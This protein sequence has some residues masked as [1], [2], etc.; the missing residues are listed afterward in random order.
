VIRVRFLAC[1]AALFAT[2]AQTARADDEA[3]NRAY[4]VASKYGNCYAKSIPATAYGTAGE[5][6]VYSVEGDTDRLVQTY[7]WFAPQLRLECNVAGANDGPVGLSVVQVGPWPRGDWANAETL[8]LAFHWNGAPVRSYSTLDI[9]GAPDNVSAS[10]SHYTV[11]DEIIGY[12]WRD[13]NR[14]TFTIRTTDGR[15]IHFDAATGAILSV[16]RAEV[17]R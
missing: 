13:G 16:T 5:T 7:D 10:V 12:A 2:G 4:V 3:S 9:A 11:I 1:A 15:A 17:T 14:Y 8:A 6:R